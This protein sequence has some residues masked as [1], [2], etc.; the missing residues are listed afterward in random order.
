MKLFISF[1]LFILSG[2]TVYAGE[3]PA[4]ASLPA[5][6]PLNREA[7]T[8]SFPTGMWIVLGVLLFLFVASHVYRNNK[9]NSIS[10]LKPGSWW[11]R[12]AGNEDNNLKVKVISQ[13]RLTPRASLHVVEWDGRTILVSCTENQI[14][15]VA[16]HCAKDTSPSKS[17][18]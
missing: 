18:N 16:E 8:A 5:S 10:G 2:M 13:T 7:V 3:S 17:K 1:I 12:L 4:I 6:L 9:K 15:V 14:S 11:Q